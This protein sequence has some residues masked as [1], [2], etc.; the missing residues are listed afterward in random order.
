MAIN[1]PP[2]PKKRSWSGF[3]LNDITVSVA[4][5]PQLFWGGS[6]KSYETF[7]TP[8]YKMDG[9]SCSKYLGICI[10]HSGE[11]LDFQR[12]Q[13]GWRSK[14]GIWHIVRC[15]WHIVTPYL[16]EKTHVCRWDGRKNENDVLTILLAEYSELHMLIL[17]VMN[18]CYHMHPYAT[19][20][21]MSNLR[22]STVS[23]RVMV[24]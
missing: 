13:A 11:R 22:Y 5:H 23:Y 20:Q 2:P 17:K 4:D 15:M 10:V 12:K 19:I 14:L 16:V 8:K 1:A 24:W 3:C 7:T 21:Y 9:Y 6:S 18:I